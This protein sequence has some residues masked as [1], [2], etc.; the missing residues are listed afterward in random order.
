MNAQIRPKLK[1]PP[2][3]EVK[4]S[5]KAMI[6]RLPGR[7][8]TWER[9]TYHVGVRAAIER[10]L[11]EADASLLIPHDEIEKRFGLK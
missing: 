8:L 4:A 5:A 9:L 6:D 10:G 2:P 1:T 11:A 7:G 3:S